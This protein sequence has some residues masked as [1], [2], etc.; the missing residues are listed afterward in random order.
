MP[1]TFASPYE[2]AGGNIQLMCTAK[3][4]KKGLIILT[5]YYGNIAFKA[6]LHILIVMVFNKIQQFGQISMQLVEI[7]PVMH[8]LVKDAWGCLNSARKHLC[9]S[10]A[11]VF[12]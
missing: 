2:A 1:T 3:V 7:S 8:L 11:V 4:A 5:E 10:T 6:K 9:R 12:L